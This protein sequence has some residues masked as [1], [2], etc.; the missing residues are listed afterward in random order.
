M[1]AVLKFSHEYGKMNVE[2]PEC[3]INEENIVMAISELK[4]INDSER[5]RVLMESREKAEHDLALQKRAEFKKGVE[6][7]RKEGC[8]LGKAQ[9]KAEGKAEGK[10][11]GKAEVAVQMCQLGIDHDTILQVTGFSE[12]ELQEVLARQNS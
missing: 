11:E 8:E 1:V 6:V 4:R 2:I 9:G 3:L 10:V 12:A 5:M 7:G